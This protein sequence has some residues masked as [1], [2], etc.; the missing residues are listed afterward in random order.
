M[1]TMCTGAL[2]AI[3]LR[4]VENV[5]VK[6]VDCGVDKSSAVDVVYV[7]CSKAFDKVSHDRLVKNLRAHGILGSWANWIQNC[8]SDKKQKVMIK[9][10]ALWHTIGSNARSLAVNGYM[11]DPDVNVG[12]VI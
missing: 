12:V 1:M 8:F 7:G 3:E 6:R 11:N 4:S 10:C 2:I 9:G 5:S